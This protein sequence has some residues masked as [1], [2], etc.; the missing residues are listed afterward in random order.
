V[1]LLITRR[2]INLLST[3]QQYPG[4]NEAGGVLI[5][6][7]RRDHATV[8]HITEPGHGDSREP[9]LFHR[10]GEHHQRIMTE[11]WQ[12]SDGRDNYLGEWHTHNAAEL[13]P[14]TDD[15]HCLVSAFTQVRRH[16]PCLFALIV[17]RSM[18]PQAT[19]GIHTHV[20]FPLWCG[21]MYP[22]LQEMSERPFE[23]C[24]T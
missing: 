17:G 12:K 14:S 5:G 21:I 15:N 4:D 16:V 24:G 11:L 9:R 3:W 10:R 1:K 19:L 23:V 20:D 8:N 18:H 7:F 13:T 6:E 22:G 2:V